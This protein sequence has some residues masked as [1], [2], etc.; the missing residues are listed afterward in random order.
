[1]KS[2]IESRLASMAQSY[3]S[4]AVDLRDHVL[5]SFPQPMISGMLRAN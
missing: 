2:S 3:F 1:V 4:G 5:V